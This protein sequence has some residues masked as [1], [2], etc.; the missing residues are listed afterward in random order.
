MFHMMEISHVCVCVR[1]CGLL[2]KSRSAPHS[3]LFAF[4]LIVSLVK[5]YQIRSHIM[6]GPGSLTTTTIFSGVDIL[7]AAIENSST[8]KQPPIAQV[9]NI[10]F[11]YYMC[12]C[13]A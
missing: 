1:L 12:V 5:P 2:G 7:A 13:A 11:V 3:I 9:G 4:R 6:H 8:H 10:I